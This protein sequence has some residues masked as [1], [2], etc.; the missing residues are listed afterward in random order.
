MSVVIGPR[1]LS[2]GI[3]PMSFGQPLVY[4]QSFDRSFFSNPTA[5]LPWTIPTNGISRYNDG[6]FTTTGAGTTTALQLRDD[7]ESYAPYP[8]IRTT[9]GSGNQRRLF[10]DTTTLISL[11][12][13]NFAYSFFWVGKFNSAASATRYNFA[14]GTL[15]TPTNSIDIPQT[16][17]SGEAAA[18]FRVHN[19]GTAIY[20]NLTIEDRMLVADYNNLPI[21]VHSIRSFDGN[22]VDPSRFVYINKNLYR[23]QVKQINPSSITNTDNIPTLFGRG[24][25]NSNLG[26]SN[27]GEFIIINQQLTEAQH[28]G[29]VQFLMNRWGIV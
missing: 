9:A 15:G 17:A 28:L 14:C 12:N 5:A 7:I 8:L 3:N 29:V 18:F 10:G 13:P 1:L 25:N 23:T 19:G 21:R 16:V 24:D 26:G 20:Q 22:L 11:I 4:Y 27:L 2:S 6:L